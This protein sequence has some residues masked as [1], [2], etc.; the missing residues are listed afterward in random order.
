MTDGVGFAFNL[1]DNNDLLLKKYED[2]DEVET[3]KIMLKVDYNTESINITE[4]FC[5]PRTFTQT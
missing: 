5:Y 2:G 1:D 4:S 3:A